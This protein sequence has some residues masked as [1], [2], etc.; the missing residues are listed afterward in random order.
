MDLL[1][2]MRTTFSA[3]EFTRDALPD[4]VLYRLLDDARFAASGGNRQGW[5]VVVVRETA[6]RAA[7]AE[8][9]GPAIRRYVAQVQAG[10]HPWNTIH[11]TRVPRE[12]IEATP[13]PARSTGPILTAPVVLVICVDLGLVASTDQYLD[14]V[15]V[16][17]GASIYP[18][19]WN[20]L[21]AARNAGYGGVLTTFAVAAEPALRTLLGIPPTHAVA[22]VVPLGR[23]VRSLTRLSRKPVESFATLE[24]WGGA[25]LAAPR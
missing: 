10:E 24:R 20:V 23:P 25:P 21:L 13:I 12:T 15:G 7:I 9:M 5:R 2:V 16:V 19:V 4:A 6:T 17:S 3:R 14:R 1:E 8:L 18:F 11:P 22:A